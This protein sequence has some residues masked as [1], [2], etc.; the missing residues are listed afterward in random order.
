MHILIFAPT[1]RQYLQFVNGIS[2]ADC[3]R[4]FAAFVDRLF[5]REWPQVVDEMPNI[6][7][8]QLRRRVTNV[9][10]A[11]EWFRRTA[12]RGAPRYRSVWQSAKRSGMALITGSPSWVSSAFRWRPGVGTTRITDISALCRRPACPPTFAAPVTQRPQ[13][14]SGVPTS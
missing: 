3:E 5:E 6:D 12:P 7:L 11:R 13:A 9:L 10:C 2:M 4:E 1:D 14:Q 8:S